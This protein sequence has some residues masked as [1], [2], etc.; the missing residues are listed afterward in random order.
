M[1]LDFKKAVKDVFGLKYFWVYLFIFAVVTTL[2]S[3]T[4][5]IESMPYHTLISNFISIFTYIASGYLFIMVHNLLNNTELNNEAISES[6]WNSAKRGLK[7]FI[8]TLVNTL[9]IFF[10]ASLI[11]VGSTFIFIKTTGN[12]ITE[13]NL[14][15]FPVLNVIFLIIVL[16]VSLFMLFILKFLTIA[17]SKEFSLKEMFCWRKVFKTFFQKGKI[18]DTF[19]VIVTYISI[20]LVASAIFLGIT[21]AFNLL[22]IYFT[23]ILLINNYIAFLLLSHISNVAG[24]FLIGM[25]HFSIQGVIY[26]LLAQVYLR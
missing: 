3:I 13:M 4:Q 9:I 6:L 25:F 20:L 24:P 14:F 12:T 7:A 11:A 22:M 23:K 2:S 10:F 8:G 18:K 26:H 16:F 15:K 17:Y 1:N 19:L 21:F 5:S